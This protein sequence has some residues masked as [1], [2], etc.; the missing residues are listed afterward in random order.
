VRTCNVSVCWASILWS[1]FLG[2]C[3]EKDLVGLGG[4]WLAQIGNRLFPLGKGLM[5]TLVGVDIEDGGGG[6][7]VRVHSWWWRMIWRWG[8][9]IHK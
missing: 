6:E 8:F 2:F 4:E 5:E 9:I 7:S 1:G 3:W